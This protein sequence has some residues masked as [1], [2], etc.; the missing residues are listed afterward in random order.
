MTAMNADQ[1]AGYLGNGHEGRNGGGTPPR[2][3]TWPTT[4]FDLT[5]GLPHSVEAEKGVLGSIL[6]SPREALTEVRAKLSAPDYFYVAAHQ[7]IYHV[8]LACG[9][10]GHGIDLITFT[11][12]LADQQLL[13]EVGGPSYVT[14]LFTFVPTAANVGYYV[15]IVREKFILR[16]IIAN[17]TETA[18]RCYEEQS[19]VEKLLN[20]HITVAMEIG[21]NTSTVETIRHLQEFVPSAVKEIEW[22]YHN[23]G[24]PIGIATGFTDLDR[25]IGGLRAPLPYVIAAR[26]AMGKSSVMEGIA[27]HIAVTNA[28]Q[29]IPV[30]IFSVE[31]T[32]EQL[33]RRM[34]CAR[35]GIKLQAWKDGFLP[36]K[37]KWFPGMQAEAQKLIESRVWIE[38]RGSLSIQDFRL[39]ARRMVTR[40]KVQVILI[41]Y[42]QRLH[43]NS[44]RASGSRELEVNEIMEGIASTAKE[45]NIPIVV[46]A[47]LNRNVEERPDKRPTLADLRESGSIEEKAR[48]VVLL[49]RPSY[50]AGENEKLKRKMARDCRIEVPEDD[51]EAN[52]PNAGWREEF[53][54]YAEFIVAKQNDGATG[55]IKMLFEKE[56]ARFKNVTK[57]LYSND[58]R[59]RQEVGDF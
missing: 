21:Q 46:L 32:G 18:R 11:Q 19:D 26:P 27:D 13:D 44:R 58:P 1:R 53:D 38:D 41:D 37:D 52:D 6:V 47:Q 56:F 33:V 50:Y 40:M 28:A 4:R 7:K 34:L 48:V 30:G 22:I 14:E 43:S 59:E 54:R 20:D 2:R 55:T 8:L 25:T 57:K 31:M 5:R 15:E 12:L 17:C 45:L 35:S 42:L 24:K 3:E 49:Y 9:E 39:L 23:R 16:E 51:D 29:G 36:A 10:S